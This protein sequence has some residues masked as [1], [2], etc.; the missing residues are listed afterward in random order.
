[1]HPMPSNAVL[2]AMNLAH[3]ALIAA[4]FGRLGW[5]VAGMPVLRLTTTG[6]TSGKPRTAML[7]APTTLGGA[8]VV[9]ASRGGDDRHP[10]WFWNIQADPAVR[11]AVGER[12]AVPM[13]ARV[14]T[15]AERAEVWPAVTERFPNYAA[16]Q[17]RTARVIPLV[18]LEPGAAAG[19]D[20]VGA[21]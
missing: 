3:R 2:R 11:V 6:R 4:S 14:L 16:Y 10:G 19:R 17:R 1:M 7:T 8:L 20:G 9:V 12:R 18:V 15:D 21:T 5:T 13:R